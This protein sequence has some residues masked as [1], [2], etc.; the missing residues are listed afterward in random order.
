MLT[1]ATWDNLEL[2]ADL[3]WSGGERRESDFEGAAQRAARRREGVVD[4]GH[5]GGRLENGPQEGE[6]E[7]LLDELG[8]APWWVGVVVAVVVYIGLDKVLPALAGGPVVDA[9][10]GLAVW[11]AAIFLLPAAVSAFRVWRGRRM[12]AANRTKEAIRSLGWEEFEELI[13]AHYRRL[14][15]RVRREAGA[16]PDGGVKS[17]ESHA[18][19]QCQGFAVRGDAASASVT[20]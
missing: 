5:G 7:L 18:R 3:V 14:G 13:E 16:G 9:I 8:R 10:S 1:A 2:A 15:F 17:S 11:V 20:S 4:D 19:C 12:L 6:L